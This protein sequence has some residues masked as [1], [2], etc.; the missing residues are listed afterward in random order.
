MHHPFFNQQLFYLPQ[1]L[2]VFP[3]ERGGQDQVPEASVGGEEAARGVGFLEIGLCVVF[4]DALSEAGF[5][6]GVDEVQFL[7]AEQEG[8]GA[9][10]EA[11]LDAQEQFVGPLSF[12]D[13][14][15][16]DGIADGLGGHQKEGGEF[17]CGMQGV[18]C[19]GAL[20]TALG[21][22]VGNE[23]V[24]QFVDQPEQLLFG[25]V[26]AVDE[27]EGI[28][29]A[30][31]VV[32]EA[33][34]AVIQGQHDDP[35]ALGLEQF[36]II[37]DH[38]VPDTHQIAHLAHELFHAGFGHD[39]GQAQGN[40]GVFGGIAD[41]FERHEGIDQRLCGVQGAFGQG[42]VIGIHAAGLSGGFDGVAEDIAVA[43][44][45]DIDGD[46]EDA[47]QVVQGPAGGFHAPVFHTAQATLVQVQALCQFLLG[48]AHP[49]PQPLD[50]PPDLLIKCRFIRHGITP[51]SGV[52]YAAS[53]TA[54]AAHKGI[55]CI[56]AI[57][58][59]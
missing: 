29:V 12:T 3:V 1:L 17:A 9:D 32:G 30:G 40:F 31:I 52:Y 46:L 20:P 15:L 18:E 34:D 50:I 43:A 13:T 6:V 2:T 21:A 53:R 57:F 48:H 37:E 22:V 33:L 51:L 44:E 49:P 14:E 4:P 11:V 19:A 45:Y 59:Q 41:I 7:E 16:G 42:R 5:D 8:F 39:H 35:E 54:D 10:A 36:E 27:E 23:D 47:G 55:L 26:A 56:F 28:F 24:A 25:I 58:V 38:A